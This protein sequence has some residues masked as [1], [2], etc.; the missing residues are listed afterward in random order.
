M[1]L[2]YLLGNGE[3]IDVPKVVPARG[4]LTVNIETETDPR[5]RAAAM[6]TLVT[7]DRPIV[8]ERSIYWQAA[9]GAQ[10][11]SESHTS[12]GAVTAGPRWALAEG[13][14]G[15]AL[16]FHTYILVGNPGAETAD[17]DR[18]VRAGLGSADPEDVP[19][20]RR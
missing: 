11:W 9:E 7:S 14:S 10:A 8:A 1:T 15:G 19:L 12:Q 6:S 20:R 4:R 18:A 3:T 2:R 5:L 16:N 17:R 13:R